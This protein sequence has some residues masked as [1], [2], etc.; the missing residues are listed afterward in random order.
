M[1]CD[2]PRRGAA[3]NAGTNPGLIFIFMLT[4]VHYNP[5]NIWQARDIT[6]EFR[7]YREH[8]QPKRQ[9]RQHHE[10]EHDVLIQMDQQ[11]LQQEE[12]EFLLQE[13]EEQTTRIAT[14]TNLSK[15]AWPTCST[16][17]LR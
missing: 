4:I 12:M 11:Q 3:V 17:R 9:R 15:C 6:D 5:A 7:T 2:G 10:S 1:A 16:G 8:P 14:S 13:A